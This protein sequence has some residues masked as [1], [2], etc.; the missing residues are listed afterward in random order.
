MLPLPVLAENPLGATGFLR[1]NWSQDPFSFGSY[2][3][4]AKGA[5]KRD[6]RRLAE[7]I[8]DTVF[9]AG[10]ACHPKYNSTVHAAYESGIMAADKILKTENSRVAI[11]G[12]GMSGL[13]AAQK[14]TEAGREVTVLEARDRIG[15]RIWT[16]SD[17]S[18][19]VDLGASWIHGTNDN[20]LTALSDRLGLQRVVTDGSFIIRGDQGVQLEDYPDWMEEVANVQHIAGTELKNIN[21]MAYLMDQDY[22]GGEVVFPQ[23]YAQIFDA[24]TGEYEVKFKHTVRAISLEGDG[25]SVETDEVTLLFDAVIVTLP[26]GVLKQGMV[27]FTPPLPEKKLRSIERLG[28]GLLDKLYLQFETVFWDQDVT[29]IELPEIGLPRGQF[30]QWLNLYKFTGAPIILAFNGA[31]PARDLA[32]LSD[33]EIVSRGL[34]VL[35]RAYPR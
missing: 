26:L 30:N 17:L 24:L 18:V 12:A 20:P 33:A 11:V 13:A 35:K 28:F 4:I 9:F 16:R 8:E 10:E 15:G 1:T 5:R 29:W 23:G 25:V 31:T 32:A 27:Q 3:Y 7:P 22:G 19:P 21:Q 6:H 14:L 34:S 2:S